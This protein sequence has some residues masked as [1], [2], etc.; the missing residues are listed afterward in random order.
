MVSPLRGRPRPPLPLHLVVSR[1]LTAAMRQMRVANGDHT[2]HSVEIL[3]ETISDLYPGATSERT[4]YGRRSVPHFVT[5]QYVLRLERGHHA[6]LPVPAW[7]RSR[8]I[9]DPAVVY[10][11]RVPPWL[12]RAY[13][14]A[15]GADGYLVDMYSW[16]A[17]LLADH[18]HDPPRLIRHLPAHVPD[19]GEFDYLAA[20]IRDGASEL[21]ERVRGLLLAEAAALASRRH[22]A[23]DWSPSTKDGSGSFVEGKEML[24]EGMLVA[25]GT[26]LVAS[27]VLYNTGSVPWRDR[28]LYAISSASP[29]AE[30]RTPPFITVPDIDPGEKAEL[31]VPLRAPRRAGTYRA[32]FK[33][34]WP[35]GVYCFPSTLVGVIATVIVPAPDLLDPATDWAVR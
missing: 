5:E 1:E 23:G 7:L 14:V 6:R 26:Q 30:L 12:V 34:G 2:A 31:R 8:E 4:D 25:P 35:N 24:P 19:G 15:F 21:E 29:T 32:C 33:M 13:D 17:I 27:W 22:R 9:T 18:E 28:L 11:S 20:P 3:N 16:A 10:G